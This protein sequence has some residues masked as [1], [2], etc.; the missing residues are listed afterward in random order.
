[1]SVTSSSKPFERRVLRPKSKVPVCDG[2]SN[3][4]VLSGRGA[5]AAPPLR[6]ILTSPVMLCDLDRIMKISQNIIW[7]I[8]YI[9]LCKFYSQFYF[10]YYKPSVLYTILLQQ[11]QTCSIYFTT[12]MDLFTL[13]ITQINKSQLSISNL[14][15]SNNIL[16]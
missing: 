10:P 4:T 9:V 11:I 13:I 12:N 8:M 14:H 7:Y 6:V 15:M 3:C 5:T 2:C 1:M 16:E